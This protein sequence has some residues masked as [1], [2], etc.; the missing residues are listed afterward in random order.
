MSISLACYA[1]SIVLKSPKGWTGPQVVD[2][3]TGGLSNDERSHID[4]HLPIDRF[5]GSR[6]YFAGNAKK[7][8]GLA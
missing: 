1:L 4:D 7:E 6:F 2:G 3:F 5:C 8:Q